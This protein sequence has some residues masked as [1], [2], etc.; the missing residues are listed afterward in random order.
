MPVRSRIMTSEQA[1]PSGPS[2]SPVRS[3]AWSFALA[4]MMLIL[5]PAPWT[6][7]LAAQSPTGNGPPLP[8]EE[9][10]REEGAPIDRRSDSIPRSPPPEPTPAL[11]AKLDARAAIASP[12]NVP[13]RRVSPYIP[14][15]SRFS[16]R[17][18]I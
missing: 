8:S 12:L 5:L 9:E 10:H 14:H 4:L 3:R 1:V 6:A 11:A 18:L 17:R 7:S 13:H 15:P 2:R 16:E